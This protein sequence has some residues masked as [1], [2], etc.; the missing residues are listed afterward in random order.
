MSRES[1]KPRLTAPETTLMTKIT[2]AAAVHTVLMCVALTENAYDML[3][4]EP[5]A[6]FT[7][8]DV[9]SRF[10]SSM[11]SLFADFAHYV[12][13]VVTDDSGEEM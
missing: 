8:E 13:V 9:E 12:S 1:K 6:S 10:S 2:G 5:G 4:L 11:E 7:R 3:G